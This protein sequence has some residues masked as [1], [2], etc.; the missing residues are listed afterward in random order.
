MTPYRVRDLIAAY[1]ADHRRWPEAERSAALALQARMPALRDESG[2]A[3]ALDAVL[4]RWTVAAPRL[5]P[6]ALAARISATPQRRH[7]PQPV[8]R[9][10]WPRLVWPN[11]AGLAAAAVAG[12]LVGWSHL[13]AELLQYDQTDSIDGQVVASVIEDATW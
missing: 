7:E 3:A 2:D 6:A 11:A 13:G 1:G 5:D 8:S 4:D 10:R 12:F 9:F